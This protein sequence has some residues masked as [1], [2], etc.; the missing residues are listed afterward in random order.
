MIDLLVTSSDYMELHPWN[1]PATD[2]SD[3][4]DTVLETTSL[5]ISIISASKSSITSRSTRTAMDEAASKG[6][7]AYGPTGSIIVHLAAT[8]G[9]ST[10]TTEVTQTTVSSL[11]A[12]KTGINPNEHIVQIGNERTPSPLARKLTVGLAVPAV[13]LVLVACILL[14]IYLRRRHQAWI[15]APFS[16]SPRGLKNSR[17]EYNA[18][19]LYPHRPLASHSDRTFTIDDSPSYGSI[20]Q[21]DDSNIPR[22][23]DS[24]IPQPDDSNIP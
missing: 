17:H 4:G 1:I 23:Y 6:T 8:T 7:P 12:V 5:P 14:G 11:A 24:N 3:D 15:T 22:P 18:E 20:P 21:P 2:G 10:F 13:I 9:I 16:R 19:S